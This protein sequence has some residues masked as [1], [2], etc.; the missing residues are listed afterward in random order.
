M[1]EKKILSSEEISQLRSLQE[2]YS[3]LTIKLGQVQL[4]KLIIQN[5]L[6][7][8]EEL[9]KGYE[10]NYM[11]LLDKETG[12]LKTLEAKYGEVT[13]NLETGELS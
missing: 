4:E 10:L 9:S 2:S 6:N 3:Q 8:L 12:I 1:S 11:E 13:I 7:K 5:Q